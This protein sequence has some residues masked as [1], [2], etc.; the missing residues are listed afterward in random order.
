MPTHLEWPEIALRLALAFAAGLLVGLNRSKS[1]HP[2]GLRTTLL[3]C[4]AAAVAMLQVNILLGT[5][6]RKP[7]S[8][9]MLDLMR[10]PLGI[11]SGIGFIGAGAIL[12]KGNMIQGVTTAATLWFV[13]VI[14]LCLGGGQIGL[15]LTS[16]ALALIILHGLK[17]LERHMREQKLATLT[18]MTGRNGPDEQEISAQLAAAGFKISGCS[19]TYIDQGRLR[20][21]HYALGWRGRS[22]ETQSPPIVHRLALQ[23]G[24]QELEWRPN[25]ASDELHGNE[26]P[27]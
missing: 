26:F 22:T 21:L 2:A 8:F 19:V 11:L 13:T 9:M 14:G 27:I 3:V 15:G 16:L 5:G 18:V 24:V 7:D 25:S 23:A 20:R 4:L 12:R 1:G 17:W 10:L 6:G